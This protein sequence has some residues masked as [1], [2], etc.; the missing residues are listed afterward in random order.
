MNRDELMAK[1]LD[2]SLNADE[3]AH[4]QSL[5]DSSPEMAEELRALE[6]LEQALAAGAP[7]LAAV[8]LGFLDEVGRRATDMI[9]A[10]PPAGGGLESIGAKLGGSIAAKIA[11]IGGA[12]IV[13]GGAG[14]A[15]WQMQST[16]DLSA[17]AQA[18][19]QIVTDI[20]EAPSTLRDLEQPPDELPPD[21]TTQADDESFEPQADVEHNAASNSHSDADGVE[22]MDKSQAET[23][24]GL[25]DLPQADAPTN[26]TTEDAE[27]GTVHGDVESE[28]ALFNRDL[29]RLNQKFRAAQTAGDKATLAQTA[30]Q[31]GKLL[32]GRNAAD[33]RKYYELAVSFAG[34]AGLREVEQAARLALDGMK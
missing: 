15:V 28:A 30:L 8:D 32:E 21:A 26:A 29:Q 2:G 31:L 27:S 24:S 22:N 4:L 18:T 13:A 12:I 1:Y 20:D 3:Q 25:T 33:S 10:A 23:Q 14:V 16:D 34:K 7:S 9:P 17:P 19:E 5:L 11:G 6:G